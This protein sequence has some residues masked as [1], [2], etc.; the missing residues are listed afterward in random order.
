M[1]FIFCI[2][3]IFSFFLKLIISESNE[4][5]LQFNDTHKILNDKDRQLD[6]SNNIRIFLEST[7]LDNYYR[8]KNKLKDE[9]RLIKDAIAKANKTLKELIKVKNPSESININDILDELDDAVFITEDIEKTYNGWDLILFI[10]VK[11]TSDDQFIYNQK[12]IPKI[13]KQDSSSRRPIVGYIIFDRQNGELLINSTNITKE[14]NYYY[15]FLH[16]MTHILGFDIDILKEK[17][18]A[19]EVEIKR[20]ANDNS[21]RKYV[22]TSEKIKELIKNYYDCN[23][24]D[25]LEFSEYNEAEDLPNSHWESRLLLGDY[26]TS[27]FYNSE[28]VISEFTLALLESTGFYEINY[29]TGGLM[30]FGKHKGCSFV[31]EECVNRTTHSINPLLMASPIPLL[32][33]TTTAFF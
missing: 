6:S 16:E 4:S 27:E 19:K 32:P 1:S 33:P 5:Y 20:V 25:Y 7:S 12:A 11:E 8:Y 13:I 9:F 22:V 24:I 10:R 23:E 28:V 21:V 18:L 2:L 30:R 17:Q 3:I 15:F 31:K 26:M 14:E 29:Y